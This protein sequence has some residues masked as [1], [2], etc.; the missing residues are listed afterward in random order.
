MPPMPSWPQAVR[1]CSSA[2]PP[3]ARGG[4][5][6]PGPAGL[7]C[8]HQLALQGDVVLLDAGPSSANSASVWVWP[9]T[10]PPTF[11]QKE[12]DW[13]LSVGGITPHNNQRLGRD[14]TLDSLPA[15]YDAVFSA[16]AW[17]V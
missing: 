8:A 12:I 6:R 4:R 7:T 13:L 2:P 10:R 15:S 3:L 5:G 14:F 9:A 17:V 16:W 1:R 11:A